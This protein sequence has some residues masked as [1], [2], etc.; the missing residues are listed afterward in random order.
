MN[1]NKFFSEIEG[2]RFLAKKEVGQNFL[3]DPRTAETIVA[4][5]EAKEGDD[6]LEIGP[7]PGSL[8]FFL[9]ST[10][11]NIDLIDI[12][13]GL[14]TK[15]ADDFKGNKRM[16]PLV[17]NALKTDYAKYNKIIGNLPYYITTSLLE[18]IILA[19]RCEKAVLMIQK[20]AFSR[21]NAKIRTPEYGSLAVLAN[22]RVK[23]EKRLVVPRTAFVPAPHVDSLVFTMDYRDDSSPEIAEELFSFASKMFLHRRKTVLWNLANCLGNKERALAILEKAN[24][25]PSARPEELSVDDFLTIL[26]L[27]REQ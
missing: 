18:K 20:E 4:F 21:V 13:E 9:S 3:V 22:Y 7:G 23:A 14:I 8:S 11:A 19:P 12:D 15:I 2:L 5:L 16:R 24:V 25:G 27:V 1:E 26:H 10:A 6:I 17:G